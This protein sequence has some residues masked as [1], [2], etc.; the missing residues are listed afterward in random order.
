M[1][2]SFLKLDPGLPTP[3][4]AHDGDGGVDLYAR[5]DRRL[6][7]GERDLIPTGVAVAVPVGY[8]ALVVPRSGLA[9]KH[10]LG[11]VNSPGLVDSGYRGEVQV[12]LINHG[13]KAVDVE[14]GE[15]IAQLVVVPV[16]VQDWVEVEDLSDSGRGEGGFGSTGR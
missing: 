14:R 12:I 7:P 1:K 3:H 2:I 16:A 9:V 5:I 11:V 8:A 13:S 10:G 6:G 15:R 4:H